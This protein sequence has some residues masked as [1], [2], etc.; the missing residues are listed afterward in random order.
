VGVERRAVPFE[1]AWRPDGAQDDDHVTG[2]EMREP[3]VGVMLKGDRSLK[4]PDHVDAAIA[5]DD[6][7]DDDYVLSDDGWV[8]EVGGVR[9]RKSADLG[10]DRFQGMAIRARSA[11]F[12]G[13]RE[14]HADPFLSARTAHGSRAP[15]GGSTR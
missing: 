7:P 12:C 13:G 2:T 5:V 14:G 1:R 3:D 15:S 8:K 9:G 10:S 6:V 4:V 11:I